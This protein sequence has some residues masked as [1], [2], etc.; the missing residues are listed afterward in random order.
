VNAFLVHAHA[1]GL[2]PRDLTRV[3]ATLQSQLPVALPT[4]TVY[5]LAANALEAN[6]VSRIFEAK[7]RPL[8]DPLIVHVRGVEDLSAVGRPCATSL[9]LAARFWPG[10]L[11]LVIPRSS[12]V[13]DIVTAG[14]PSVAVRSPA[15]PVFQQVLQSCDFPLAAPSA[16]RFGRISPTSAQDVLA[17]LGD[18]ISLVVDGGGCAQG[19]ESTIVR[20]TENGL[21]ILRPGPITNEDL[22]EFGPI[23][24]Q[25]RP[26]T[27]PGSMASHYAPET[28]VLMREAGSRPPEGKR[29]GLLAWQGEGADSFAVVRYLSQSRDPHEAAA[30]L[31]R[32]LRELDAMGLEEIW[33][34][35]IPGAGLAAAVRDRMR[36][37]AGR[38]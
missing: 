4:E 10:P 35:E 1:S 6:A 30:S 5:G 29:I 8:T 14:Q 34:E 25:N 26:M 32:K 2:D 38:G 21:E 3:V 12:T 33:V 13:P 36:R 9:A 18:C 22:A 31:Y 7:G 24:P 20:P 19:I 23:V 11:T 27:V 28:H 15:H 17:E 37:A 16:N